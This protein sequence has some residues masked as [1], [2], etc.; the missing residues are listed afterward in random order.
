MFSR[1][2]GGKRI[3][4]LI[5]TLSNTELVRGLNRKELPPERLKQLGD[6][7]LQKGDVRKAVAYLYRAAEGFMEDFPMKSLALYKKILHCAPH[8]M[9]AC[10]KIVGI[11]ESAGLVAEQIRY[12]RIMGSF[13]ESRNNVDQTTRAFRRI[14][15]LDPDNPAALAFF[16]RGKI[17]R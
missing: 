4:G 14:L 11:L 13:Y 3:D 7:Y 10:E 9:E 1:S 5:R 15:D 8:E 12:L 6:L 17:S 16:G 2:R